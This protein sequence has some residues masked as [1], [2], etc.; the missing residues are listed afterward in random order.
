MCSVFSLFNVNLF[1]N[2]HL[3][4][5]SRSEL[6]F[7]SICKEVLPSHEWVVLNPIENLWIELNSLTEDQK[8][9]NGNELF[10]ILKNRLQVITEEFMHQLIESMPR[11]CKAVIKS[12]GVPSKY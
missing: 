1:D 11:R 5:L 3:W 6:S 7:S 10:E 2:N 8:S 9:K 4:T 12:K